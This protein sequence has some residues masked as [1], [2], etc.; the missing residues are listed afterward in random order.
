MRRLLEQVQ[1]CRRLDLS[2][3]GAGRMRSWIRPTEA[4]LG[5]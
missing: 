3:A 1:R 5:R 2:T 4:A